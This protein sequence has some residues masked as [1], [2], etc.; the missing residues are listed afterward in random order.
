MSIAI[1]YQLERVRA[2]LQRMGELTE[3]L[4]TSD[5]T[6]AL[7]PHFVAGLIRDMH[8]QRQR[9][10]ACSAATSTC[11]T[12]KIAE[13]TGETGEPTTSRATAPST[14]RCCDR[15][16]RAARCTGLTVFGKFG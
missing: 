5:R 9:P 11:L 4:A 6:P 3:L 10:R 14:P 8:A 7:L 2:Q 15:R 16:A 1:V 13:R 12:R